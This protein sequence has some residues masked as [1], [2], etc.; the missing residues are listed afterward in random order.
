MVGSTNTVAARVHSN[1]DNSSRRTRS[2]RQ[3]APS[4]VINAWLLLCRV[5]P[6]TDPT[7]KS[8][9]AGTSMLHT[10]DGTALTPKAW[11]VIFAVSQYCNS[12][13]VIA[14]DMHLK[15]SNRMM[16]WD[17]AHLPI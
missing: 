9:Q 14:S 1:T 3:I 11:L 7:G 2:T 13:G 10:L 5:A 17:G 15:Q 8:I 16:H 12:M 4:N 6:R